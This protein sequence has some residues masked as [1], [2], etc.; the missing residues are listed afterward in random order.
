MHTMI[1]IFN[2]F[3][4]R[5]PCC[6]SFQHWRIVQEIDGKKISWFKKIDINTDSY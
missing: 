4:V 6:R 3:T 2:Y 5:N 1:Y